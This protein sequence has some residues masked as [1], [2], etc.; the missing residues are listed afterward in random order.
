MLLKLK[1]WGVTSVWFK[2]K[3]HTPS[4][5][6]RNIRGQ[7]RHGDKRARL[8]G[9]TRLTF[10]GKQKEGVGEDEIVAARPVVAGWGEEGTRP[11]ISAF[12]VRLCGDGA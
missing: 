2:S 8:D 1:A 9:R 5:E 4:T 7:A 10:D 11:F 6:T 12:S 3:Q